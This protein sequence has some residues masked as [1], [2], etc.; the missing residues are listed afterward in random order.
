ME[1]SISMTEMALISVTDKSGIVELAAELNKRDIGLVASGGT[2]AAIKNAGL[3]VTEVEDI[4][5]F[6]SILDGRVKT[7]HPLIFGG[8]LGDIHKDEHVKAM[9]EYKIS[10]FALVVCNFYDF[11]SASKEEL[12]LQKM[13]EKIDIGGPSMLRAAAKNHR[14]SLPLFDPGSYSE[15]IA[16]IDEHGS[17]GHIPTDKRVRYSARAF[18]YTADYE[19][20]ISNYFQS[21]ISDENSLPETLN[22][23]L[24]KRTDM[25]YG[26]NP[27]QK[28]ALYSRGDDIDWIQLQGKE[29]SYNNYAD[30][31]SAREIVIPYEK[32]ASVIIKHSNPCGFGFGNDQLSAYRAA[33]STDPVSYFGGIVGFN[34]EVTEDTAE[35]LKKSFLECIIA[36]SFSQGAKDLLAKKKNL[37]LLQYQDKCIRKDLEL[38]VLDAGVLVQERDTLK[39]PVDEWETVTKVKPTEDDMEALVLGWDLVKHV[40]SNA[41]VF[42]SSEKLLGV[43]AGQMSRV[44]SV[45]IAIRKASEAGLSL[46]GS[47]LASD[48]FFPFAD[49]VEQVRSLKIR[50]IIQPGGSIRD[51]EVI[52][53]CDKEGLFMIFTKQRHFR[54]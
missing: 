47:I 13:I 21:E 4:T 14:S 46:E 25:R 30:L 51:E 28:A 36:P 54:H 3:P 9:E 52:E 7:L 48:A 38:K 16:D 1:G 34:Y 42:A 29:L 45:K 50:G 32:N 39:Q 26:E 11:R 19:A 53:A 37:R 18:A 6:P 12:A 35:E 31:Q 20:M 2:A 33:V 24:K 41:I 5:G 23:S 49:V 10:P 40:K 44:D 17:L 22:F 15:L 27:F 8:V 43:G